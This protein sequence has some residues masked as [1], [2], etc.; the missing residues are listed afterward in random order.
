M[1]ISCPALNAE[2]HTVSTDS[3]RSRWSR[4]T[5]VWTSLRIN[6]PGSRWASHSTW[7][8]LQMPSTGVPAPAART[9]S[10]ITGANRAIA[11]Q[12]R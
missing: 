8:P 12:R 7:K 1:V 2:V 10:L 11:P 4:Q 6:A 5:K 3:T 9:T